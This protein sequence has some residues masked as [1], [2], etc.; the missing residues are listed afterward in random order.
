MLRRLA[1][2][3]PLLSGC[4]LQLA[5]DEPPRALSLPSGETVL[6]TRW[7]QD[8]PLVQV[9]LEGRG[10]YELL[11]DTG[12]SATILS[13]RV[14]DEAGLEPLG[15][16]AYA[17]GAHGD[18]VGSTDLRRVRSL[19]IGPCR[20]EETAVLVL[21]LAPLRRSFQV[22]FDGI[23]GYPLFMRTTW[24][25]DYPAR[26]V[27]LG[28]PPLGAP[29]GDEILPL[30]PGSPRPDVLVPLGDATHRFLL[31][32]GSNDAL[33]L[34]G[35][36]GEYVF[37]EFPVFA[38]VTGSISGNLTLARIGRLDGALRLGRHVVETPLAAVDAQGQRIGSRI[39]KHFEVTFD[40][41][42]DRLRLRRDGDDPVVVEGIRGTGA[43]VQR[44]GERW[45]V[46]HVVHATPAERAGLRPGDRVLERTDVRGDDPEALR[47]AV[48]FRIER[49]GAEQE[50]KVPVEQL[51]K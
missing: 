39:L 47:S 10:P 29:D 6:P 22:P 24:T 12:S 44:Y 19:E 31:D 38:E 51:V 3:L 50:L 43:F 4:T 20:F 34:R 28:A 48:V 7:V 46:F 8:M 14:A 42:R 40:P 16:T 36:V 27:R 15:G 13:R 45:E 37:R 11:I 23:V 32:S 9:V 25:L 30:P 2:L 41:P 33:S 49:D 1:L 5:L 21:D 35:G 17:V 26:Q 18:V